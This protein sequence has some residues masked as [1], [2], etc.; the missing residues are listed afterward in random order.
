[1]V[2]SVTYTIFN[3]LEEYKN[4]F[5]NIYED[6]VNSF[7][8]ELVSKSTVDIE[9]NR[10]TLNKQKDILNL[11]NSLKSKL[12]ML[13][14][15]RVV[16][17]IIFILLP[18]VFWK[19]NPKIKSINLE[20]EKCDKKIIDLYNESLNQMKPL[21]D[22]FT[23]FDSLH[24]VE[25]SIPNITYN[26]YFS[27]S[28]ENNMK[29]NYDY[30]DEYNDEE[31]V[32][33]II[34]GGYNNNPFIY[35]KKLVHTMG[36]QVYHGHKT[37]YWTEYYYDSHGNRHSRSRSQTLHAAIEK[38]KPFYDT[39]TTLTYCAQAGDNLSFSRNAKHYEKKDS[40]EIERIVRKGER[41]LKKLTDE[42]IKKNSD[43][44]AMAN[45]TF[46]VLFEAF[47]RNDE[48]QFRTL[49]SPLAQTNMVELIRSNDYFGDDFKFIKNKRTNI[50]ISEH[51]QNKILAPKIKDYHSNSYDVIKENFIKKNMAFFENMYFDLAPLLAIPIL[52]EES[53]KLLEL[54]N[55]SGRLYSHKEYESLAS[56]LDFIKVF[57][58]NAKTPIIYKAKYLNTSKQ[59]DNICIS[60]YAYDI[61]PNIDYVTMYGGD[62][63]LHSVPAPWDEYI[64]VN[65]SKVL[66]V[67]NIDNNTVKEKV[68]E[69]YNNNLCIFK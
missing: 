3:P 55:K 20:I 40:K 44:M 59:V 17:I 42:A 62:G 5:K 18:F 37:I 15:L 66:S 11:L 38:P 61:I 49:F 26:S 30:I 25:K 13:K 45:T 1:M 69:V 41:N 4:K 14:F 16:M 22:L 6:N 50:I 29:N 34:S 46:E 31:T 48:V 68:I 7:F 23:D 57:N 64:L 43:F 65:D 36:S 10:K 58:L 33:D 67:C 2:S 35:E 63:N 28:N 9:L 51:S 47:D 8:N 27:F 12:S 39:V 19:I 53:S 21:N 24:L 60:A 32:L 54:E 52:Q 56:R